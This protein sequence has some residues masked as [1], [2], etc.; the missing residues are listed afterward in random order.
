[1]GKKIITASL[2]VLA[3]LWIGF[4]GIVVH[5]I[6]E[7]GKGAIRQELPKLSI[8]VKINNKYSG[9]YIEELSH[10]NIVYVND[11]RDLSSIDIEKEYTCISKNGK[12]IK[13]SG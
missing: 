1:M 2:I 4:I 9:A 5:T 10:N 6:L 7:E 12:T 11:S 13:F 8:D 3:C